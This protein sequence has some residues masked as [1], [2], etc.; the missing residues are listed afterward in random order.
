MSKYDDAITDV[1]VTQ[2]RGGWLNADAARLAFQDIDARLSAVEAALRK[3]AASTSPKWAQEAAESD[4]PGYVE[5]GNFVPQR[6][7]EPAPT[8]EQRDPGWYPVWH[9]N[10]KRP[11]VLRWN[12]IAWFGSHELETSSA[13]NPDKWNIGPRIQ[14]PGK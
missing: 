8:P 2:K 3:Q 11:C 13:A 12:G 14:E 1:S 10:D 4:V 5:K 9:A 7:Q 6:S